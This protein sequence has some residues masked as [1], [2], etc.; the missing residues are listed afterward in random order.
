MSSFE[1]IAIKI[2]KKKGFTD[3][4]KPKESSFDYE[5]KKDEILYAIEVKG[6]SK[7]G[8]LGRLVVPWNELH[9]LHIHVSGENYNR[10]SLL[11]FVND[12]R[13]FAIFEMI[14]SEIIS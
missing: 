8:V 12:I 6:T 5:A 2:L 13:D 7:R 4:K 9:D 1:E 3:F 10:K 11:V 14:D